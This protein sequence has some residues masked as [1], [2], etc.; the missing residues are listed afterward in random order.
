V[1]QVE[2]P[3][4]VRLRLTQSLRRSR[5][6]E[7]GG[8]LFGQE[9]AAGHF[10]IIDFSVDEISGKRAHFTRDPDLHFQALQE[11]FDKTGHDYGTYNYLGEWHSHPCFSV[12]P[13]SQDRRSMQELVDGEKKI[14]FAVLLIVKLGLFGSFKASSGLYQKYN[15]PEMVDLKVF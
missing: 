3:E 4:A 10:V 9:V 2:I 11:F 1:I 6:R 8:I 14:D 5:L 7:I 13:S 15:F 12:S